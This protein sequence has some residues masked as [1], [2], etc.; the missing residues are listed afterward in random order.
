M[1]G[2]IVEAG[3]DYSTLDTDV[4]DMV[5]DVTVQLRLRL[6]RTVDDIIAIG[7]N[8]SEVKDVLD[9]G[10]FTRWLESEFSLT[11]RTAQRFMTIHERFRT[12]PTRVSDLSFRAIA[13]LAAPSTPDEI[14]EDVTERAAK[15]EK[16]TAADIKKLKADLKEQKNK[17][18]EA[19]TRRD[20]FLGQLKTAEQEAE[21]LREEKATLTEELAYSRANAVKMASP[22]E[23]SDAVQQQADAITDAWD[24]ASIE[25]RRLFMSMLAE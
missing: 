25:A 2:D 16:F 3:F 4:R 5:R 15:G 19:A 1:A 20:A 10:Q 23:I 18:R 14:V 24:A 17:T 7:R 22:V 13:E 6:T 12:K 9:H 11:D 21:R 8:L